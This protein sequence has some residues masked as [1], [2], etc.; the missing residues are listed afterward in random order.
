MSYLIPTV[1]ENTR[2]GERAYDIYS[3]LLKERIIF[4]GTAIDAGVANA[5]IAQLL[6]LEK[7]NANKDI[8]I[9]VNSPGGVVTAGLAIYD[10]M[11]YVK[12]DITTICVGIAASMGSI[13]LTGGAKGKRFALANSEVMIHQPMGGTEGQA[14]DIKI[15]ADHIIKT[16]DRLNRILANHTGQKISTIENDVERDKYLSS[17]EA[18]EYGLIDKIISKNPLSAK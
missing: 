10:T 5:V 2:L 1:I 8:V 15:H 7:E 17:E 18:L 6:F 3:R 16:R 9:Y 11:Q 4:I 14:S 12:P 13:L